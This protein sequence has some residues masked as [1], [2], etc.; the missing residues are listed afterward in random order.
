MSDNQEPGNYSPW[1][2]FSS[3]TLGSWLNILLLKL[4]FGLV[5]CQTYYVHRH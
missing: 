5:L 1:R 4:I 2:Y 3:L